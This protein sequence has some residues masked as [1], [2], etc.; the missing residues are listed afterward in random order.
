MLTV[1]V[2]ADMLNGLIIVVIMTITNRF[3]LG[4]KNG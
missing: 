2:N 4:V 1:R 3:V